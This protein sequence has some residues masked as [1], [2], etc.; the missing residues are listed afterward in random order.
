M[1]RKSRGMLSG[2]VR[3]EIAS[4]AKVRQQE[5][6]VSSR[7]KSPIS[8][9]TDAVP[10]RRWTSRPASGEY[11]AYCPLAYQR[12]HPK[13]SRSRRVLLRWSLSA[14]IGRICTVV[15]TKISRRSERQ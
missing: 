3:D 5:E 8:P 1:R 7:D 9:D 10:M 4:L 12:T 2:V 11:R 13:P 14:W 6:E 15:T